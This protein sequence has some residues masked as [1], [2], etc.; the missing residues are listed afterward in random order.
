MLVI[1]IEL[2]LHSQECVGELW[3]VTNLRLMFGSSEL[4]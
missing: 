1:A 4:K 3:L 2:M